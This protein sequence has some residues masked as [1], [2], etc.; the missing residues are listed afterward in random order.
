MFIDMDQ[1]IFETME[2]NHNDFLVNT[3]DSSIIEAAR[4]KSNYNISLDMFYLELL[5][6]N[7]DRTLWDTLKEIFAKRF[8]EDSIYAFIDGAIFASSTGL[9]SVF[10]TNELSDYSK[11]KDFC[12]LVYFGDNDFSWYMESAGK[13]YADKYNSLLETIDNSSNYTSLD[14]QVKDVVKEIER[15]E[16]KDI[17]MDTLLKGYVS[18]GM[19][20]SIMNSSRSSENTDNAMDHIYKEWKY[21][22]I[23]EDKITTGT[24]DEVLES[25]K[26]KFATMQEKDWVWTFDEMWCNSECLLM[27]VKDGRMTM[28]II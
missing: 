3:Y 10:K 26:T 9:K 24:Y 20:E 21:L 7:I 16:K 6:N 14:Y 19:K 22:S 8:K 25:A 12:V 5:K 23:N 28:K 17:I 13:L 4:K 15:M 11:S 18:A 27:Y 1:K 2:R